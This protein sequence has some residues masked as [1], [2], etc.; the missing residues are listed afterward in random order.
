MRLLGSF[1]FL[2]G[3]VSV[4]AYAYFPTAARHHAQL[5]DFF[6]APQASDVLDMPTHAAT[7]ELGRT[8][9]PRATAFSAL[10]RTED[11]P[12]RISGVRSGSQA[13][14][15]VR[16]A[17]PA[18]EPQNSWR[19]LVA[20]GDV[21][22][23]APRRDDYQARYQLIR[24]LQTEL[25]RVGCYRGDVDGDWG[26]GS[27]RAAGEFLHKVNATLPVETP[28][29]ILLTLIQG[30]VDRACGVDCPSGQGLASDGRCVSNA[31]IARGPDRGTMLGRKTLGAGVVK[32]WAG[33]TSVAVVAAPPPL[34]VARNA[35]RLPP[36]PVASG[37]APARG[38][39]ADAPPIAIAAAAAAAAAKGRDAEAIHSTAARA[40]RPLP[41]MMGV[42]A[43]PPASEGIAPPSGAVAVVSPPPGIRPHIESYGHSR[44]AKISVDDGA[45]GVPPSATSLPPVR[46]SGASE[47][48]DGKAHSQAKTRAA[49]AQRRQRYHS[50]GTVRTVS[51]RVRRGSPQHN[52][53]LSLGGVF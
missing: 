29:Y 49:K 40:V 23:V 47:R 15:E 6:I 35:K 16:L 8:F 22:A 45:Q 48:H 17:A 4:G 31:V 41:G 10:V 42:G 44:Q 5:E 11:Q 34:P 9:S 14:R 43:R 28:D 53:M 36:K 13:N 33:Q 27:K 7:G 46:H 32:S 18:M 24:S 52:L 21:H 51:G 39:G 25:A 1:T 50:S 20:G 38:V 26:P 30:H 2:I 19:T 12:A 3:A 37:L